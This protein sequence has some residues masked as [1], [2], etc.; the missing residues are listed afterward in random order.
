MFL[1]SLLFHTVLIQLQIFHSFYILFLD[2][3]ASEQRA[4]QRLFVNVMGSKRYFF[5]ENAKHLISKDL[6]GVRN[7][8]QMK[9]R[10]TND[11][12]RKERKKGKRIKNKL[13]NLA[14]NVS[15]Q[16]NLHL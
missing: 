1:F 9:R 14:L 6:R 16:W 11:T 8:E 13:R 2:S 7:K 15:N 3:R 5:F 4:T 10:M 12:K